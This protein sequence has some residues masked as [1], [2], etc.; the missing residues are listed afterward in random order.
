MR[1]PNRSFSRLILDYAVLIF[2][3]PVLPLRIVVGVLPVILAFLAGLGV[4]AGILTRDWLAVIT[5]LVGM[6]LFS[7]YSYAVTRPVPGFDQAFRPDG[8]AAVDH[9]KE[10]GL[11]KKPYRFPLSKKPPYKSLLHKDIPIPTAEN[12]NSTLL[13]DIWE[14]AP[15]LHR[16]GLAVIHMHATAWQGMDKGQLVK[17]LFSRLNNQGHLVLDLAYSLAP[18]ADIEKMTSEVKYTI[19]WLKSRAKAYQVNPEKIVLMG[20][21]G[22]GHLALLAAYT[23][24]QP[25]F[26][27]PGYP[28]DTSV[29]GVIAIHAPTDLRLAFEE[30]GKMEPAQPENSHEVTEAMQPKV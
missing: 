12:A 30:Y 2:L 14:P 15:E 16:S 13:C 24:N 17:N 23:Q 10:L 29:C 27:P 26:Q 9:G 22:G 20:E 11:I 5:G 18:E 3:M 7:K 8:K 25:E 28:F 6:V 4:V 19:G 21:S 1:Q